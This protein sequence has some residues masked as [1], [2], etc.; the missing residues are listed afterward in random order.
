MPSSWDS[1]PIPKSVPETYAN[2][3]SLCHP[4]HSLPPLSLTSPKMSSQAHLLLL[5][6]PMDAWFLF[7]TSCFPFISYPNGNDLSFIEREIKILPTVKMCSKVKLHV[8]ETQ[9]WGG[10]T[11]GE[12]RE[13]VILKE[14]VLWNW[15][16]NLFSSWIQLVFLPKYR[17]ILTS[18]CIIAV[19]LLF[20]I[21]LKHYIQE[22]SYISLYILFCILTILINPSI[23]LK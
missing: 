22:L 16:N 17:V 21:I 14:N 3:P 4:P 9:G 18:T 10:I 8:K 2:I 5:W 23:Y 12:L 11:V 6:K 7:S 13:A 1:V 15:A 19:I 20:L